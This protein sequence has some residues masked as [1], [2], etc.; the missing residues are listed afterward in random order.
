VAN[1]T[2]GG[3]RNVF[4][5]RRVI[6]GGILILLFIFTGFF[7]WRTVERARYWREHRDEPI[8]GWMTVG[9]IAHSYH[10]PSHVLKA[11]LDLPPD[12]P[13]KRPLG[14]NRTGTKSFRR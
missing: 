7:V 10:V 8:R 14:K 12:Q 13:D 11:A 1:L 5:R 6:I 4:A 9:Y 2:G 3:I